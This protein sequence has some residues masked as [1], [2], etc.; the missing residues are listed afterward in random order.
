MPV[1]VV[2]IDGTDFSGKSTVSNLIVEY[3]R[4]VL[5]GRKIEIKKTELP[6]TLITGHFTKVLRNSSDKISQKV[7]A[8]TYALDHLHHYES[9]IK[10]LE[11]SD[12]QYVVI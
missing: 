1:F 4:P 11:K 10:P 8:L 5:R 12:K 2:S 3:L 9:F 7:F 6:S